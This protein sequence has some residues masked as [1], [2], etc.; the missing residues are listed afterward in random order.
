MIGQGHCCQ[1]FGVWS[2]AE[3]YVCDSQKKL[4][5]GEEKELESPSFWSQ[6]GLQ[7][8]NKMTTRPSLSYPD[9]ECILAVEVLS[10]IDRILS[11]EVEIGKGA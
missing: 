9:P 6:V 3:L 2:R 11:Y 10:R 1:L 5:G 7:H 8:N 4:F